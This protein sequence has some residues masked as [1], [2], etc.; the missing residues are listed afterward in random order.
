M[1][2]SYSDD[3]VRIKFPKSAAILLRKDYCGDENKMNVIIEY[4]D[5]NADIRFLLYG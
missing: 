5:G 4:P 3:G 1:N 2:V